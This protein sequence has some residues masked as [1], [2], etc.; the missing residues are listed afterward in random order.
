MIKVTVPATTANVGPG[1][2][3]LGIALSLYNE[4]E[5]EEIEK[6]LLIEVEGRDQEKI[7]KNKNNLIYQSMLRVFDKIGKYPKGIKI[8][9]YNN[10]PLARG[11]GSSAAC[12]VGGIVA[13]NKLMGNLLSQEEV[14]EL[15]V[16]IEGHPDNVA[17]ALLG[18][19]VVSCQ[20]EGK[21]SYV[22]FP[23]H[24]ALRFIVAIPEVQLSTKASRGVLPEG[25]PFK[26]AVRNVGK[27]SLLVAALMSGELEKI[28][29][30]LQ[31][32]LHQPYRTKLIDSLEAI[33]S[34]AKELD[35]NQLFLSGAGPSII[36][37]SWQQGGEKEK[38][39][40]NLVNTMP[41]QWNFKILEGDNKGTS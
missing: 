32:C 29:H 1:F 18:G 7:E 24:E 12:I 21:T 36:Y 27:S 6:G 23:V 4:I 30:A 35:L 14:L 3:C 38:I 5:V 34:K 9:Q 10:I 37:L 16:E 20:D 15:A 33:F 13:A 11:L 31:D 19:V 2:D 8:K 17:P 28:P 39:F 22:R 25:V 40:C 41:E 26:D